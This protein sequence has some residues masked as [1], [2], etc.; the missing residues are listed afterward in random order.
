MWGCF[1]IEVIMKEVI[2]KRAGRYAGLPYEEQTQITAELVGKNVTVT[3]ATAEQ[4]IASGAATL[5]SPPAPVV[6]AP[7]KKKGRKKPPVSDKAAAEY[8]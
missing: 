3:N 1:I 6:E 4:A 5:P 8:K 7:K 2:F